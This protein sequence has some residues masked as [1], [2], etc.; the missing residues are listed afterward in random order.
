[1][2]RGATIGNSARGLRGGTL[3][4][5]A[6]CLGVVTDWLMGSETVE[7]EEAGMELEGGPASQPAAGSTKEGNELEDVFVEES[8]EVLEE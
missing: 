8:R 6:V 1:M 5:S 4:V 3:P 2:A 7:A